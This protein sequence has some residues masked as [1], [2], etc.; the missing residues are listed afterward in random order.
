MG[1][2]DRPVP[3]SVDGSLH[4]LSIAR[5]PSPMQPGTVDCRA[6]CLECFPERLHVLRLVV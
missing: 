4:G 1:D 3:T 6:P 2:R 5:E